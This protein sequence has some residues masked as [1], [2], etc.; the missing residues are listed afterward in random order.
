MN[1]PQ[2]ES[3]TFAGVRDS[4]T[5]IRERVTE[6]AMRVGMDTGA[7]YRLVLAVDE[8]ATNIIV[9]GYEEAALA[10]DVDVV[11]RVDPGWLVVELEDTAAPFDP[12]QTKVPT[13][14]ELLSSLDERMPGG[15]GVFLAMRGVDKFEYERI[16]SK[17]CTR[18]GVKLGAE[19][20]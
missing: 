8:V 5:A 19:H 18:L 4:L 16:D 2:I 20:S 15:L 3:A 12:T 7:R 14:E 17:N 13:E 1:S 6:A 9:H 11:V 10:G